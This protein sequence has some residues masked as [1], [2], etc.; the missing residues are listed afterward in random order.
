MNNLRLHVLT[1][2]RAVSLSGFRKTKKR[3]IRKIACSVESPAALKRDARVDSLHQGL[4][5]RN[6]FQRRRR[7]SGSLAFS[8]PSTIPERKGRLLVVYV[9]TRKLLL[10]FARK[11]PL[12]GRGELSFLQ[13]SWSTMCN[14]KTAYL[15]CQIGD[16]MLSSLLSCGHVLL[17]LKVKR[18]HTLRHTR[19]RRKS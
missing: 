8:F 7:F 9:L 17:F 10:Y 11:N 3:A 19:K 4:D 15:K 1:R 13:L 18:Q 16:L 2:L 12:S 5:T 14:K 6:T